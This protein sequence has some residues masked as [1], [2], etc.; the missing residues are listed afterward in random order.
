MPTEMVK[1]QYKFIVHVAWK[2]YFCSLIQLPL[3]VVIIQKE[4]YLLVIENSR[5]I[6]S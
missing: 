1:T 4:N 2:E 5:K 6:S 3:I